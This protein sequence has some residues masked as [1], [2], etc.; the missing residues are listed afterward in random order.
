MVKPKKIGIK[1]GFCHD[2]K[3]VLVLKLDTVFMQD[4]ST[5]RN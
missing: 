1:G 2:N 5:K 4:V 3:L